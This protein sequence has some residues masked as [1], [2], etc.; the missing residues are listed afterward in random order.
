[1]RLIILARDRFA[2]VRLRLTVK[3]VSRAPAVIYT[4]NNPHS[5]NEV[6]MFRRLSLLVVIVAVSVVRAR[7]EEIPFV[8]DFALAKDRAEALKQLIPG[9]ED[10]YYYNCLHLQHS[11][12]FDQAEE[13]LVAW[14]KRFQYTARV[15]EMLNRQALLQYDKD[16]Q[17]ALKRIQ[18]RLGL[19]FNHQREV[20]GQKPNLPTALDQK[21]IGREALTA[22]ALAK[23]RNVQGF[24]DSALDWV[25]SLKLDAERQRHLLQR[26]NRPDHEGLAD[27]VVAD[28]NEKTSGGF[29]QLGIH[30]LLLPE[31]L[32]A[33][34][35]LKPELLNHAAF[36][37]ARL[38]KLHP[39]AHVD[40]QHD[41]QAEQAYLDALWNAVSILG[42]VHNSLKTNVLHRRLVFDRA[43]GQYDKDRFMTYIKLPR[44]VSYI[45]PKFIAEPENQRYA[46]NL[47]A[48]YRQ[49]TLLPVVGDD[50]PLV[51]SYLQHFFLK[52]NLAV[53]YEPYL[54]DT[55]LKHVLAETK[56]VN[57]LG[58]PEQWSSLLSPA[59]FK[60]LKDRVD[61][62]FAHTNQEV[63]GPNDPVSI[64]LAVKNVETLI[65]KVFEINTRNYYRDHLTEVDT[66]INLDGL[67]ANEERTQAYPEP[68][69]R[70]VNR[71]FD[72][73]K[74]TKPGV[75]VIDF[76][77]NGKSSRVL[78]RKG[79][80][81]HLVRTSIAGHVFTVL[82]DQNRH[83]KD[84][85]LWLSDHAYKADA[86]GRITVPFS[87][88][89]TR[90][91]II[92]TH[93]E[94]S[95]LDHFQ[96]E[97]ESYQLTAGIHIDRESLLSRRKASVV[98]RP[99]L[100][101]N[102]T[103][104][105]LSVLEDVRLS[106]TSRDQDGT[107]TTKEVK[108]FKLFED[109]EA[110]YEFQV[111]PRLLQLQIQLK[112]RVPNI[113]QNR[114]D[115]VQDG[116][117][118]ALNAINLTPGIEDLFLSKSAGRY[119]MDLLGLSGEPLV[120]RPVSV[121]LKHRDFID[122]FDVQLKTN[123]FGRVS[124]GELVDVDWIETRSPLGATHRW[125]LPR[126]QHT[127]HQA[128]YARAGD[129]IEIPY[130]DGDEA[131]TSAVALLERRGGTFVAN[132]LHAVALKNGMLSVKGLAAGEYDLLLK[133]SNTLMRLHVGEGETRDGY[134]LGNTRQ[135][136]IRDTAPLQIASVVAGKK[137]LDIELRNA[138]KFTR[139]H[140]IATRYIPAYPAY[141]LLSRVRDPEPFLLTTPANESRFV[142][143]RKI[144]DEYRYIIDR[145]Y[146][147][148]FPGNTLKR[149]SLILN[150]W[151]VR[152]TSTGT[153]V[154]QGGEDFNATGAA[155]GGT[156]SRGENLHQSLQIPSDTSS[157]EFLKQPSSVLLNL[158]P[159][160]DGKV[161]VAL[162]QLG[163]HQHV[164]VVAVDPQQ[165]ASRSISRDEQR[166]PF[167]DL[168]LADGLDAKKHYT[169]QKRI[170][171][172]GTKDKFVLDDITSSRFEAYDSLAKV[173]SLYLTL[174][175]DPKLVEFGFVLNW[176]N[177]KPEEKRA[178]YSKYASHELNFFLA[179]KDPKFF[180]DVIVPYLK[181]KQ[182]K[183]F[184]DHWLVGDDV[185][186]F[187]RPWE[188]AQL[189]TVERVL[190]GR[191][192]KGELA[193]T[194]RL[195]SDQ[196]AMLPP[197][198]ERFQHLYSTAL[199][200]SSL[201]VDDKLGL[202]AALGD[203]LLSKKEGKLL[204]MKGA[205]ADYRSGPQNGQ[206]AAPPAPDAAAFARRP[207]AK[208]AD[209]KQ[210][211]LQL[212]EQRKAMSER[213]AG[214]ST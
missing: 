149:P 206:P 126:D 87:T 201:D 113:S 153:Q 46:A 53:P 43:G 166:V 194:G 67:V 180:N 30:N 84:A 210:Q 57:G 34:L 120:D 156:S 72:F 178:N 89:P 164:H 11:Q 35:K 146:A 154:A 114:K 37:A 165:T 85:T 130:M 192:L 186:R 48:D 167:E 125:T 160:K 144:G 29:G 22:R 127:Y 202:A 20:L 190:L 82:D 128:V 76:I 28:L 143:G 96:H 56:I 13:V 205:A 8:E 7:T 117:S 27:L 207:Q 162:D 54:L 157:L 119:S 132:R 79:K 75:Y 177:L 51:R 38:A 109:R 122:V 104:V 50:E 16:P 133:R 15:H 158:V 100:S 42:P 40:W 90:Q 80:L 4:W 3:Q 65:V 170:S 5:P 93:G 115:A 204:D 105:T 138:S 168:R 159:D 136:E 176:P 106:I 171:V 83:L 199:G 174:S 135:L 145:K 112:A 173:Y 129:M 61:L 25:V 68:P 71:Q 91:P 97:A 49:Q 212:V 163:D 95:S 184:L 66:D 2:R 169:Q 6:L 14:I 1:M 116:L 151:A 183:T 63:F 193:Y 197:N 191:K 41:R 134:V 161:S 214:R 32:D 203:A 139:V 12:K 187:R 86:D 123:D 9:T 92:L 181:N 148:K 69:L 45:N 198:L 10:F 188:Y 124:L 36:V 23:Y 152:S 208:A 55:Y 98:V 200:G 102:G 17:R 44:R 142:A 47:G 155:P 81:R 147:K 150:P 209:G 21:L 196:V 111:P 24:E 137:S 99:S 64:G 108:D 18:E 78:V 94:F 172:L 140:V 195:I 60:A 118:F 73:P 185:S 107:A 182:H 59:Q 31:Q 74:I 179:R 26:L 175:N 131:G 213:S 141:D 121:Q 70:R 88:N 77:G 19:A 189:N 110:T 52:E 101:I 62:E 103:P 39:P 58:D 211:E 33:V